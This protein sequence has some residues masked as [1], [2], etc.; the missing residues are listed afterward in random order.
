MKRVDLV[1]REHDVNIGDVCGVIEPNVTEDSI[2][3]Y[4][5]EPI[6]F[7]IKDISKYNEKASKL[8]DLANVE[9][10]SKNVPKSTMKRSSGFGDGNSDKEVL[11]KYN[12]LKALDINVSN[13]KRKSTNYEKRNLEKKSRNN[14]QIVYN[15]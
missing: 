9:L 15:F 1:Y 6:G 7:Y 10:R 13:N 11:Q 8:A 14:Q 3:Y 4:D 2:F 12:K 5:D